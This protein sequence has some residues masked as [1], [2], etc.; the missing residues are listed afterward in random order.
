MTV[1]L[2]KEIGISG[3]AQILWA[4]G[5]IFDVLQDNLP[6]PLMFLRHEKGPHFAADTGKVK[7]V[8]GVQMRDHLSDESAGKSLW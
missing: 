6:Q 4:L 1:P 3:F 7:Q 5:K 8:L 2:E